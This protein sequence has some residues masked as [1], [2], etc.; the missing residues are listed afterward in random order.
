MDEAHIINPEHVTLKQQSMEYT[1]KAL[2][3]VPVVKIGGTALTANKDF[4]VRYQNNINAGTAYVIVTGKG[5]YKG[6]VIKTF[7]ITALK[8]NK[9][10][11]TIAP[12]S[13]KI[14]NGQLQKPS[15][16]V[17]AGTKKLTKNKDYTVT[18][19]GNLHAST[20]GKKAKVIITGKGNYAGIT[21]TA[22]FTILPQKISKASIKGSIKNLS[23]TYSKKQLK[24]GVQYKIIPDASGM[25]NNKTKVTITGL[26]DFSG[27]SV[28]KTIKIQ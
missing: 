18:Y 4:K 7:E 10:K 23:V 8:A 6:E 15:V 27:S 28:T 13:D 14:Y 22:T 5:A 25:K 2:Q 21:A 24:E 3:S 17:K 1:G 16:T 9:T 19:A 20:A 26:G 11:L 12:I